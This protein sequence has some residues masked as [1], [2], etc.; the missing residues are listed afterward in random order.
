[1]S[2]CAIAG[3]GAAQAAAPNV[4]TNPATK[5]TVVSAVLNGSVNPRGVDTT[6]HFEYGTTTKY[7]SSTPTRSAGNSNGATSVQ[8]A[9][10]PLLPATRYHFRLVATGD[11]T[12]RGADRTFLTS[13]AIIPQPSKLELARATISSSSNTIDVLAPISA[14]AS[15]NVSLELF[16]ARQVHRW[17]APINSSDGR[18]RTRE[19]IPAA[20][21]RLGT[22]IL[23]IRYAGD[24]DTR[25]QVVRLRA[26]NVRADLDASRPTIVNGRL[27]A[28]G[29]ISS[30][31]RGRVRVQLEYYANGNTTTLEKYATITNGS[32]RLDEALTV[33]QLAGI[34][35][36]RGVVHSYILFTGY[37]P[38]KMR[39]EM[40]SYEVLGP[41]S[42]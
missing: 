29:T 23:T 10:G 4:T 41:P 36:R 31:A 38:E 24:A 12:T 16:G 35:A 33:E 26:A 21:A 42:A 22:G 5:V 1:M 15:G 13:P 30:A 18:I 34:A 7:G 17:T 8:A 11:G 39:G 14:R 28:S 9:I 20:Q 37:F 6:Y 25:P 2:C 27:Q 19:T 32:W 3:V 40:Q